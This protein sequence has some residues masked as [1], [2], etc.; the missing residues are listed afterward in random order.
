MA[1]EDIAASISTQTVNEEEFLVVEGARV[2]NLKNVSV[3]IPRDGLTVITGLSGSGKSSLAFDVIYAEG[4]R[5]YMETLS[6]YARQ[7]V[8]AMER[9]DVDY[10]GGLSPVIAIEQRTTGKNRRSTVG[11]ITEIYDFLRLLYSRVATAYSPATGRILEAHTSE[12]IVEQVVRHFAEEKIAICVP[13]VRGRK[14][15][16]EKLFTQLASRGY[17]NVRVDGEI[18]PITDDMGLS[19]YAAHDIDLVVDRLRVQANS[20]ERLHQALVEAL[21][22]G[23]D[24]V[25]IVPLDPEKSEQGRYYSRTLMCPDSG[26]ALPKPEPH[27]F[28]FN[29]PYGACPACR[30]LGY[31]FGFSPTT[32]IHKPQAPLLKGGLQKAIEYK[33]K[34]QQLHEIIEKWLTSNGYEATATPENL[35]EEKLAEFLW[36]TDPKRLGSKVS[37]SEVHRGR[38]RF[39]GLIPLLDNYWEDARKNEIPDDIQ[40][41]MTDVPC[42]VC[43]GARLKEESLCFRV[44]GLDIHQLCSLALDEFQSWTEGIEEKLDATNRVV[45]HEILKEIRSRL[46]FLIDVG[47]GYLSLG[48]PANTLSG[49]ES[50]R[51]R[52]ATQIGTRLVNVLY[53]LDEPSIGLHPRDNDRLIESLHTLRNMGNTI[54][55]VE[56]DEDM[57]RS[58]DYLIDMGPEAGRNGGQVVAAGKP[59]AVL[60]SNSVTAQY[61]KGERCIEVPTERREGNGNVFRIFGAS[62]NNLKRVDAAFPLGKFI[63]VTGVSGSG[64]STLVNDTLQPI[65]SQTFYR[66]NKPPLAYDRIEGLEHIDKVI[67]VD[68]S[69]LGRTPRSNPAT[70]TGVFTDI[71][72]L[73]SMTPDAQIR[74][75]KPG[76]FSFNIKGGRCENCKG[77]GYETIEMNF[78]PD[79]YVLCSECH[80]LRYNRETLAVRYKGRTISQVLDMTITQAAEF[81]E[82]IPSISR[83]LEALCSV[84]LGYIKLGQSST[85]LSGG[86]S[87]RVR[88]AAELAKRP[89]GKT[90]YILDEPTTGLHFEDIR[91]LLEVIDSLVDR[92]NTVIVIEHNLDVIKHADHLIDIGP[93]SGAKGGQILFAGTPE[94]L[95]RAGVGHTAKYLTDL[96]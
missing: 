63:C 91:L 5:R 92:G 95:A 8:G 21:N 20:P 18:R 1:H 79:V 55:V 81:F 3:T 80:G 26:F 71:R 6:A 4:Q 58:A 53:I 39:P 88:L 29:S 44:D 17:L 2:H 75:F 54:I 62:G 30:G 60:S 50:Q 16:Y 73:F 83:K 84:G 37:I 94:E 90:L 86:E 22:Y 78:L 57:M 74:G 76:R 7:F 35:G 51:I 23:D 13:L 64:K 87:Q 12:Q 72:K 49:G 31:R 25:F 67:Q 38:R 42:P 14:G 27:T 40:A 52:L 48:R 41:M 24:Q 96:L 34:L 43:Q 59:A 15:Q 10:V 47:L 77:G 85:T 66:S 89:S 19:R 70:Y 68:Q 33:P 65:L 36:G 32:L 93:E 69:P 82:A 9:P 56:H 61:L 11:T 46:G 45:A 28:S